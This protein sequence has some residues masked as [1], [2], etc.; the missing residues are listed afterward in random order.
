MVRGLVIFLAVAFFVR[1]DRELRLFLLGLGLVVS[2]EGLLA[3]KQRYIY[4]LHRVP[5]SVDDSNSLSVFFC[6]TAPIFVAAINSQIPKWLKALGAAAIALA[7]VGVI[8]TISRMGV[9]IIS[10]VLIAATIA[11][12]SYKIT[13]RK[14]IVSVVIVLAAVGAVA[15]SWKTLQSRFEGTNLAEEYGNNRNL[16]R[17]YYIRVAEAI[18]CGSG[19]WCRIEQ[20][21]VLGERE[22]RASAGIPFR[23]L[24]RH[25]C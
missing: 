11:T 6:T 17:G 19:I 8:L 4:G 2:Y 21:V 10:T 20:L 3:L 9:V 13:A 16:G 1:G 25:R 7:C 24:Q 23:A 15:K 22:V 18:V 5:G 14:L 12:I